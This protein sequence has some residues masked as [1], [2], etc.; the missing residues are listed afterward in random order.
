M[1]KFGR[2]GRSFEKVWLEPQLPVW[3]KW[4]KHSGE[5]C[6]RHQKRRRVV[7][8]QMACL[9]N[10]YMQVLVCTTS[11]GTILCSVII[12]K[13]LDTTSIAIRDTLGTLWTQ[14]S[15]HA[16]VQTTLFSYHVFSEHQSASCMW[17]MGTIILMWQTFNHL[18]SHDLD[19]SREEM[20]KW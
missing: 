10:I 5:R 9:G 1:K 14:S 18:W 15:V 17:K 3:R 8:R 7:T 2:Y 19:N 12:T 11:L 6:W 20:M 13:T 16:A 4:S